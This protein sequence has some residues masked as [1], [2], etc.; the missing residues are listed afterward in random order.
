MTTTYTS[1]DDLIN[2]IGYI[3]MVAHNRDIL[4][5]LDSDFEVVRREKD[6]ID[7]C[8]LKLPSDD[9][10]N[11]LLTHLYPQKLHHILWSK[12]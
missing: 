2:Q 10:K 4:S 6:F 5:N 1:V 9:F 8:G 7:E 11:Y 12:M 3:K